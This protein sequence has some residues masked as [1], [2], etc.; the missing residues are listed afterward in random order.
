MLLFCRGRLRNVQRFITHVHSYCGTGAIKIAESLAQHATYPPFAA[1][2]SSVTVMLS[3]D[4]CTDA[5]LFS[6]LQPGGR[7]GM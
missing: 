5:K 6:G 4:D 7:G 1:L 3:I 2:E